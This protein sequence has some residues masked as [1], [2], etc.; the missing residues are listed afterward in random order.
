MSEGFYKRRRGVLEH[1][2]AGTID[3]L[4]DGIHDYLSMKANLV[5]GN[6]YK[7]PAGVVKTSA[8]ALHAKCKRLSERT[9]QRRL[10]HMEEIGWLKFSPWRTP[11]KRGNYVVVICRASVHD[12]SGNEYRVNGEKT[13][14][15]RYPVYEL[16]ADVSVSCRR[17]VGEVSGNRELENRE[18][19]RKKNPAPSALCALG[20]K[21]DLL[22]QESQEAAFQIFWEA[23]PRKQGKA[24]ARKA[25]QEIPIPEYPAI[26]A[27]LEKW[28]NSEQWCRG[29]IPHPATWL[30]AKRWQDEDIPQFG[31]SNGKQPESFAE[32]NIR[33]ADKELGEVSRRAQQVLQKV[34][35]DLPE[36]SDR[37]ASSH[38]LPRGIEDLTPDQ[39]EA[40]CTEATKVAE[41]FPKPGHIRAAVPTV[42]SVFL[43]P[44]QLSYPEV[45][46]EE[47]DSAL[48][49]S[50]ALRRVLAKAP[51]KAPEEKKKWLNPPPSKFTV[52]QQREILRTKGYL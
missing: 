21:P 39:I 41:Q 34:G 52:E 6:G 43:G 11:G 19:R 26:T 4:D 7:L 1:I 5:I 24:A 3:L 31:E 38:A 42:R 51:S 2:D 36:S 27:G 40:G 49:Y 8:A 20:T 12:L 35:G 18:V 23:W 28:R 14:D 9:I 15:W 50:A 22:E 45:S 44:P 30:N 25:W 16:V 48:E 29:V 10:N 46:Q 32:R 33:R 17:S 13:T 37:G 47:R